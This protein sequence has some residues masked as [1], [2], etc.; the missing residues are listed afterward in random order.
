MNASE[1]LR[2]KVHL[3]HNKKLFE[4]LT[5]PRVSCLIYGAGAEKKELRP[6][7]S[8]ELGRYTMRVSELTK[9]GRKD[10]RMMLD[11]EKV[12]SALWLKRI[13]PISIQRLLRFRRSHERIVS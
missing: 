11:Y 13:V 9:G 1:F 5:G 10:Y 8:V 4:Q 7:N 3:F 2:A 6:G 12:P